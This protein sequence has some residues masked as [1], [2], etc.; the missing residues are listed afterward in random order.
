MLS[1]S[2]YRI[3]FLDPPMILGPQH[4]MV[5]G[6]VSGELPK[7]SVKLIV[8]CAWRL[9][10]LQQREIRDNIGVIEDTPRRTAAAPGI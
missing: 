7:K 5:S 8:R 2:S 10:L 4:R 9:V 1:L 3:D 6:Q